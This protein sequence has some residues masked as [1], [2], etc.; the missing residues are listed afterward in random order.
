MSEANWFNVFD[1]NNSEWLT[2]E[3]KWSPRY[4][5]AAEFESAGA[6]I[7]EARAMDPKQ[8]RCPT[9]FGDFGNAHDA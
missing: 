1:S 8:E 3:G 9:V 6:A 7:A 4:H 5:G 2:P